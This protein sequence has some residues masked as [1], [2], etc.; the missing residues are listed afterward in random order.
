MRHFVLSL[1]L[2][3]GAM[4][5]APQSVSAAGA[6]RTPGQDVAQATMRIF[7]TT[8]P[9][10]GY[11]A[12]C[13]RHPADCAAKTPAAPRLHLTSQR[14]DELNV[15]NTTVNV[16]VAPVTDLDLYKTNEYW[17]YPHGSGDCEDYVL[18]K[19]RMLIEHGWPASAL[20]ITVVLDETN[21]G[22]AVLTV[23]TDRGDFVLDNKTLEIRNWRATPYQF[24]KRQSQSDPMRWVSL[25]R[26]D[27]LLAVQSGPVAA[28]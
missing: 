7:E 10:I 17:D 21:L 20:L 2:A 19:K 6:I 25:R 24:Q 22:H 15:I 14:W 4:S 11:V 16:T 8:R 3:A 23:V 1:F 12:F 28:K 26:D 13:R 9:P 18:E 27:P 5:L